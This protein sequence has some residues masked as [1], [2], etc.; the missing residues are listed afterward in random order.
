[1]SD[2]ASSMESSLPGLF[3]SCI[4]CFE[5]HQYSQ[6]PEADLHLLE[7]RLYYIGV[8][9]S[10]WGL[11]KSLV[12]QT[13]AVPDYDHRLDESRTLLEGILKRF[14]TA[15]SEKDAF[16]LTPDTKEVA[17]LEDS[18]E[19]RLQQSLKGWMRKYVTKYQIGTKHGKWA[20]HDKRVLENLV[21]N[22]RAD[23]EE[24]VKLFPVTAVT[25]R[26]LVKAE[27]QELDDDLLPAAQRLGHEEQDEVMEETVQTEIRN[28]EQRNVF[29]KFKDFDISGDEKLNLQIG[30]RVGQGAKVE[31][32]GNSYTGFRIRG[33]GSVY[34]GNDYK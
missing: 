32:L 18:E 5:L 34:I 31:G 24:L 22:L 10:R 6:A 14:A 11:S 19:S 8:S 20:I 7:L 4:E 28:R 16:K 1:M 13:N 3:V 15:Q 33:S 30:N 12:G 9:L 26:Q 29:H 27:V 2:V 21:V 23:V 17:M 25:Q